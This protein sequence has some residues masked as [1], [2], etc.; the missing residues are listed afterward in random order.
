MS[1]VQGEP[2]YPHVLFFWGA[3]SLCDT[4]VTEN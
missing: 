1:K 2:L 3:K 4:G